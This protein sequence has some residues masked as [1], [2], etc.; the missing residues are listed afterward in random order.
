MGV[1]AGGPY[2]RDLTTPKVLQSG[3]WWPTLFQYATLFVR[4]CDESQCFVRPQRKDMMPLHLV[5][6]VSSL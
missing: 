6:S 2:S 5:K 4:G 1:A 3:Y